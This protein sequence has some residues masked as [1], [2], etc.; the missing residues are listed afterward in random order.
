MNKATDRH[1]E[2]VIKCCLCTTKKVT[3]TP[4]NVRLHVPCLSSLF[5]FLG[6]TAYNVLVFPL[7][8]YL[9]LP[10][11]YY[12]IIFLEEYCFIECDAK[13]I[14]VSDETLAAVM[15]AETEGFSETSVNFYNSTR[16]N[17]PYESGN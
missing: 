8:L 6:L 11:T 7:I 13:C 1:S 3:L 2:Y 17:I 16:R 4:L 12:L 10:C 15:K 5:R 9:S 14:N